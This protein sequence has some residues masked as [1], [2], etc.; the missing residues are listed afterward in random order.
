MTR[1]AI[2][3]RQLILA[4]AVM[5]AAP[6]ASAATLEKSLTGDADNFNPIQVKDTLETTYEST[7]TYV[8]EGGPEATLL[9]TIPAEFTNVAVEDG[10]VC[11]D[12]VS[13][14]RASRRPGKGATKI[15]CHLPAAT[16]ATLVVS[17]ETR[18]SPGRGH[19]E[20]AFA[21]TSCELLVLND[22]AVAVERGGSDDDL[23]LAGP[24][25]M[26]AVDVADLRPGA[27]PDGDGV[28]ERCDNCPDDA[29]TDQSDADGDGVGDICDNCPGIANPEQL[30]SDGDGIGDACAD[31]G[32]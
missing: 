29:N 16:D 3:F 19:K 25:A 9:D 32:A 23:P 12:G 5:L 17:F 2:L 31:G 8:S 7:I 22:G 30:D 21:P 10:G 13:V 27:D 28:G 14:E 4:S 18:P 26:L 15:A 6:A 11:L 20:P 24:T 1:S